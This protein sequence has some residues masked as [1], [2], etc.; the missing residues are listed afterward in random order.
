MKKILI[1][2]AVVL[3]LVTLQIINKQASASNNGEHVK[4]TICHRTGNGGSHSITVDS[5]AVPAHLAHGDSIGECNEGPSRP[6]GE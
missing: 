4:V 2:F 5:H 3:S 1:A 6:G